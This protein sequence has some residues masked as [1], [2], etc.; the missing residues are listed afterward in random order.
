MID[1]T[2]IDHYL[3]ADE[4]VQLLGCSKRTLRRYVSQGLVGKR[5]R[6]KNTR[7]SG[8]SVMTLTKDNGSHKLDQVLSQLRVIRASQQE[9]LARLTSLI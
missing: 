7:Y 5:G 4:A 2:N 9:I 1:S 8:L 6:G 3:T